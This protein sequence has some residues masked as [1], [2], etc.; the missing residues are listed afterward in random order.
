MLLNCGVGEDSWE[1]LGLQGEQTSQCLRK[2]VLNIHGKDLRLKLK[3]QYFGHLMQSPDSLEK[4]L[5]LRKIEDRRRRGWQ[6]MRWLD[7]IIDSMNLS[8]SKLQLMVKDREAWRAAVHGVT[9]SWTWLG[10]WTTTSYDLFL[11]AATSS[12]VSRFSL[13][14]DEMAKSINIFFHDPS[15]ISMHLFGFY[16]F[17][18]ACCRFS[19]V[20]LFVT[21]GTVSHQAPMSTGFSRQEYWSGLPCPPPGDLLLAHIP[22][23]KPI[24]VA[25]M[26][27]IFLGPRKHTD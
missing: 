18:C 8:L 1:S 23:P 20:W 14:S 22:I 16:W 12:F 15:D 25:P 2:S 27:D 6:R 19:H 24:G 7:G 26:R 5:M 3:L 4:I 21:P 11:V 13:P 17:T 10:D 9:K